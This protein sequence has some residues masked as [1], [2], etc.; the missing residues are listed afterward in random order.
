MKNNYIYAALGLLALFLISKNKRVEVIEERKGLDAEKETKDP[1]KDE[2]VDFK[3][4]D[5]VILF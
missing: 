1:I 5:E 4:K 2:K 3:V